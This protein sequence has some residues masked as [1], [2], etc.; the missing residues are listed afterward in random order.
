MDMVQLGPEE[1]DGVVV[2]NVGVSV[3][4]PLTGTARNGRDGGQT[5]S[6]LCMGDVVQQM[7]V[8][9]LFIKRCA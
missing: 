5:G 7:S 9:L 8:K 1:P 2:E 4:R 3:A 6:C